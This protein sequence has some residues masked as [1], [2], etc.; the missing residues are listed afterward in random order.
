MNLITVL[1]ADHRGTIVHM[2]PEQFDLFEQFMTGNSDLHHQCLQQQVVIQQYELGLEK[3]ALE[4]KQLQEKHEKIFNQ[5]NDTIND[6]REEREKLMTE[7]R[8]LQ[9]QSKLWEEYGNEDI[10]LKAKHAQLVEEANQLPD[11]PLNVVH[12][13]KALHSGY[14][15][16][17]N[18][19]QSHQ[20]TKLKQLK[21]KIAELSKDS[22]NPLIKSLITQFEYE[23][24]ASDLVTEGKFDLKNPNHRLVIQSRG[25]GRSGEM[26]TVDLFAMKLMFFQWLQ[27]FLVLDQN[28]NLMKMELLGEVERLRNQHETYL[29]KQSQVAIKSKQRLDPLKEQFETMVSEI[30]YHKRIRIYENAIWSKRCQGLFHIVGLQLQAMPDVFQLEDKHIKEGHE[31]LK[32]MIQYIETDCGIETEV[33][34]KVNGSVKPTMKINRVSRV[35]CNELLNVALQSN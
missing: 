25:D 31:Q 33:N 24:G 34:D 9:N 20:K 22:M 19:A 8:N 32:R 27:E 30:D 6:M 21:D 5:Q 11:I 35:A 14:G 28:Y 15:Q 23:F 3:S 10:N 29:S 7:K 17:L 18:R 2:L 13:I 16:A 4:L 26:A 1:N 12:Q